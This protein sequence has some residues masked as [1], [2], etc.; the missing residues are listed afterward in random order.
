MAKEF[1]KKFY[2]SKEWI[3]CRD[4][5]FKKYHEFPLTIIKKTAFCFFMCPLYTHNAKG[6]MS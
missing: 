2:K 6:S 3:K 5:I 1:A 4:Y